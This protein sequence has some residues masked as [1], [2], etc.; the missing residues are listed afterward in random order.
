MKK[1]IVSAVVLVSTFAYAQENDTVNNSKNIEE[2]IIDALVKKDSDYSNKM[3]LKA[4]EDPQVLSSISYKALENQLLYTIDDAYRNITGLQKMWNAT[5]R[6]GDGGSFIILRGFVSTGSMR[7]GLVA[8]VTTTVDAINLEKLE[9]LKGPSGTLYGS[10]VASYGGLVNRVTKKPYGT[11]GGNVTVT[12]GGYN[13]YR[14]QADVNAPLTAD[15]KL[16]FRVNTAYTN[17]GTFQKSDMKNSYFAFT[18]SLTYNA[19]DRLQFNVEYEMFNNRAV[20]EQLFFYLSP[21]GLNGIDNMKD[22]E[23]AGLDYK[24]SFIGDDLYT[25][26]RV[27]NVFGQINYKINDNI[28]S[29][30][31]INNS[32]SFSNGFGP[33]FGLGMMDNQLLIQRYDQG[34]KDSKKSWFQVQQNFNFDYTFGNGMRN[35]TVAGFDFLQTKDRSRF[36]YLNTGAFDTVSAN[37]GDYSGFNG[38]ALGALYNN[39]ANLSNYDIDSDLNTYSGYV[40]NVFTPVSGLNVVLGLRYESNDSKGGKVWINDTDPYNQSAWSPKAGLVY[41]IVKD[42]FSVFGNYQNSFKSN[43]YYTFNAAGETALSDP[44]RA[45]QFEG[46]FKT[47][48]INGKINATVSYY[49]ITAKNYLVTT[50]YFGNIAIQN[51]TGEIRSKGVE[52]EVNAYLVKGFSLIGGLAYNDTVDQATGMRPATSGSKWLANFN[53]SY[54]FIDGNLKGLGFGVGGNYASD[55]K[56]L[57]QFNPTRNA[58]DTFTLNSFFVLNANA[59]YDTK[60][61]RI[62]LKVD[63]FTNEHYWIGYSTANPQTLINALGS[64]TYKF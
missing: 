19:S 28:K 1:I 21:V 62:G 30:T 29:S 20:G 40:S 4:I 33:Y 47:N 52:L 9:V 8:P 60:K 49:D 32:H 2:V 43:G 59:Y 31:N 53:A 46:G 23:K 26:A 42:K 41:E 17:S 55:N 24:Q 37:G 5:S 3:P 64:I 57:N 50:G 39:P 27:N 54:Q 25:T 38:S 14:A 22:L 36:I 6:A 10:N 58:Q 34:T 18:P 48:L 35:R 61:F 11:F 51:Q 7:N 13:T 15:K 16:L 63:N 12:G 45:N 56:I 44:E